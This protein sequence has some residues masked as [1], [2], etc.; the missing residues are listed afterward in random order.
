MLIRRASV[1]PGPDKSIAQLPVTSSNLGWAS[2]FLFHLPRKMY[3]IY[4][5]YCNSKLF[6][7]CCGLPGKWLKLEFVRP[8]IWDTSNQ[9]HILWRNKKNI[10]QT[11]CHIMSCVEYQENPILDWQKREITVFESA[12]IIFWIFALLKNLCCRYLLEPCK[13]VLLMSTHNV[14][15]MEK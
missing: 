2:D 15:F 9:Y 14:C 6:S 5:E 8:W 3:R 10:M 13:E 1:R 7:R 11:P 12:G 4:K